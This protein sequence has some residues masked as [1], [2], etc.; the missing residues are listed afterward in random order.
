MAKELNPKFESALARLRK[1][2]EARRMG[3]GTPLTRLA[4]TAIKKEETEKP[5]SLEAKLR[6]TYMLPSSVMAGFTDGII[7]GVGNILAFVRVLDQKEVDAYNKKLTN[8]LI[9]MARKMAP[10]GDEGGRELLGNVGN[11]GGAIGEMGSYVAPY[12]G[13]ARILQVVGVTRP[14]TTA[15]AADFLIGTTAV[16]PN[17]ENI[18][19]LIE[20]LSKEEN[21]KAL[22]VI[23]SIVATNPE[24]SE[25]ENRINN[26]VA[27]LVELG[28]SEAAIRS[29]V[30]LFRKMASSTAKAQDATKQVDE[31]VGKLPK[32]IKENVEKIIEPDP[33]D[34]NALGTKVD[35]IELD[36]QMDEVLVEPT[37]TPI[38]KKKSK[39]IKPYV[40]ITPEEFLEKYKEIPDD[41][42]PFKGVPSASDKDEFL[43]ALKKS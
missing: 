43:D 7:K 35:E 42:F 8:E 5:S 17:E 12:L 27:M 29:A 34:P 25:F 15:I 9:T 2:D 28:L 18:F 36:Q 22:E 6:A 16:S 33:K 39:P 38:K 21:I 26:G 31:A 20:K 23:G 13:F 1:E 32:G 40:P 24:N 4:K 41:S 37:E 3:R 14:L 30:G 10:K 11:I 19:N